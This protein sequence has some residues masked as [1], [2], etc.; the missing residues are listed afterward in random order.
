MLEQGRAKSIKTEPRNQQPLAV[1]LSPLA[2]GSELPG[3]RAGCAAPCPGAGGR[4]PAS[5]VWGRQMQRAE[6]HSSPGGRG[7]ISL[8]PPPASSHVCFVSLSII[9]LV[10]AEPPNPALFPSGTPGSR[11]SCAKGT[12]LH[13]QRRYCNGNN[14]VYSPIN[15]RS[16]C[17]GSPYVML[18]LTRCAALRD[19][20]G[21]Q[22][23]ANRS[24]FTSLRSRSLR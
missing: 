2:A 1:S 18:M 10:T 12:S 15:P 19:S 11:A 9:P 13:Q 6:K 14:A 16:F 17:A 22:R 20:P 23:P 8:V 5:R 3:R 7:S 4:A 21:N 24:C